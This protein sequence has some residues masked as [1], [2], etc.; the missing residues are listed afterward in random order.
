MNKHHAFLLLAMPLVL[1]GCSRTEKEQPTKASPSPQAQATESPNKA[2]HPNQMT[3]SLG[4]TSSDIARLNPRIFE[5]YSPE[6]VKL[7]KNS[8]LAPGMPETPETKSESAPDGMKWLI[9]TIELDA[10]QGEV[11]ISIMGI[12]VI[13]G[14]QRKYRVISFGGSEGDTFFDFREYDKYKMVSPPKL[15]IRSPSVSKQN[16]LFAISSKAA[17]LRLEL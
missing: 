13:D 7:Q 12:Q 16:M 4:R 3:V 11:S 5:A 14:S 6:S 10:T 1:A 15:M 2:P 17:G 8:S 9:V